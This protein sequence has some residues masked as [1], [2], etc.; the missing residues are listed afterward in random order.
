[1][2]KKIVIM[3]LIV[4]WMGVV[5]SFSNQGATESSGVS[6]KVTE[7]IVDS[8]HIT[9]GCNQEDA[10]IVLKNIENIVR[11]IAHFSIY[12]IGG[13]LIYLELNLYN[14][15]DSKK[16]IYSQILGSL[17][18]STD[19]LHQ[20]IIPGRSGE[21]RDVVIDSCG[22]FTGI[23]IILI[24]LTMIEKIKNEIK[25]KKTIDK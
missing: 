9:E 10:K 21:I 18:A 13:I 7:R 12:T 6:G 17:Y 11:K 3:I 25:I 24:I 8:L 19:E 23:I 5:F 20:L 22:I 16:I 1:M 14:I 15:S 2:K 4:I